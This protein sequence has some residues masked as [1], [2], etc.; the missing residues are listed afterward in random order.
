MRKLLSFFML[1]SL[2]GVFSSS[3]VLAADTEQAL[4]FEDQISR[5]QATRMVLEHFDLKNKHAEFL[6]DCQEEINFCLQEFSGRSLFS[7]IK[8]DPL[9]LYPDVYPAYQYYE[10]INLATKLDL[11]RGYFLEENSPFRPEQPISKVEALKIALNAAGELKGEQR[12]EYSEFSPLKA[13][14]IFKTN[15]TAQ[16]DLNDQA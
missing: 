5:G 3:L 15:Y 2:G 12:F 7:E 6:K 1:A 9:V 4:M 11:V 16:I 8:V 10:D 13:V 14:N